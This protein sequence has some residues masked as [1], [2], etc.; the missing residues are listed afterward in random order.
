MDTEWKLLQV[1]TCYNGSN[2]R[3]VS[4]VC[5][6]RLVSQHLDCLTINAE[7]YCGSQLVDRTFFA[8]RYHT[9][10]SVGN[11]IITIKKLLN[12]CYTFS[13]S[14][15]TLIEIDKK[16]SNVFVTTSTSGTLWS[17]DTTEAATP[18][19][20]TTIKLGSRSTVFTSHISDLPQKDYFAKSVVIFTPVD[21]LSALNPDRDQKHQESMIKGETPQHQPLLPAHSS[22]VSHSQ[23]YFNI[24]FSCLYLIGLSCLRI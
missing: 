23:N 11:E 7:F 24:T 12:Q 15:D 3:C 13:I 17:T 14:N 22:A 21:N 5:S 6:T 4:C 2:L 10:I 19:L 8:K 1:V 18:N 9:I 20:T 16:F